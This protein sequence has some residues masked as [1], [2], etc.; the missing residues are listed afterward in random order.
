VAELPKDQQANLLRFL[1]EKTIYRVG[2]TRSIAVDVRVIAASHVDLHR[3]VGQGLFREDLYYR[4][5]VLPLA[6]PPLRERCADVPLLAEHFFRVYAAD[7]PAA[8]KGFS[9]AATQ[10]LRQHCWPGNV[11]ELINRTRRAMVLAEGRLI[12]PADLGLADV[13]RPAHAAALDES[14]I[15][16]E[17]AAV[18]ASLERAGNNIARAARDL[19]VSR[20]TLYRLLDKHDIRRQ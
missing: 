16:A 14:R 3:A 5:S 11:R 15:A 20:M 12:Q 1:Q 6:V 4:L 19:G 13:D 9:S 10:A 2:S 17:R 8:L 7:K 18:L